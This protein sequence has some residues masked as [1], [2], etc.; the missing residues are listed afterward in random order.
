MSPIILILIRHTNT[1][2]NANSIYSGAREIISLNDKGLTQAKK[3]GPKIAEYWSVLEIFS[4]DLTR[5]KQTAEIIARAANITPNKIRFDIRL[6]EV[7]IGQA[8]GLHKNTVYD[9]FPEQHFRT[10]SL[11][12]DFRS[13]GGESRHQVIDRMLACFH[14]IQNEFSG[15]LGAIVVVSHGTALR[16]IIEELGVDPPKLHEQGEYQIITFGG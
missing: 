14:D 6:R 4:S 3:L 8:G 12:Y 2:H 13:I 15:H 16:T 7:D 5:A 1:D 9:R 11:N 10:S